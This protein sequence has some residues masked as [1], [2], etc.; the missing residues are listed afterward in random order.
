MKPIP[1]SLKFTRT[2]AERSLILVEGKRRRRVSIQVGEPIQDVET[3]R[4]VDW[5]CPVR[6]TGLSSGR[7]P[8]GIG[9]DSFQALVHALAF[10][11][12][13]LSAAE[14]E[15]PVTWLWLGT[16]G[17]SVPEIRPPK[18]KR[19]PDRPLQRTSRAPAKRP[20]ETPFPRRSQPARR[21]RR[22]RRG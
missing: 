14:S 2:I 8:P 6:I 18:L 17:H 11:E 4:G 10:V 7:V 19:R 20:I 1:L 16:H 12:A 15:A 13:H 21:S 5:R 22:R 9:V 3:V